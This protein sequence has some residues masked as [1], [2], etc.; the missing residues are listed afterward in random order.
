M[1]LKDADRNA[2]VQ[3]AYASLQRASLDRTE[4]AAKGELP[5]IQVGTATCGR[6]AGA[7]ETL[8]TIL[9]ALPHA[10][11]LLQGRK[12]GDRHPDTKS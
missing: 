9:P 11:E 6:A 5:L 12:G 3:E 4:A 1:A 8:E 7:L 10:I 2:R